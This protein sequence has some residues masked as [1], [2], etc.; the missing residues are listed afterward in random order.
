MKK[1]KNNV[2]VNN[3]PL[4]N[5]L[6]T[7]SKSEKTV[8]KKPRLPGK[9]KTTTETNK[10]E[11]SNKTRKRLFTTNEYTLYYNWFAIL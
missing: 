8:T 2:L 10:K 4:T 6:V 7:P 5:Q 3:P 1:V 11:K 9:K